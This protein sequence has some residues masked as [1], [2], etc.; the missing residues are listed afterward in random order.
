MIT[1]EMY[2]ERREASL[3]ALDVEISRLT[4]YADGADAD[5]AL[6]YD[7]VIHHLET[8]RDRAAKQLQKLGVVSCEESARAEAL[9]D[10][11]HQW[12]ELRNAVLVAISATYREEDES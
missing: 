10:M 5:V 3:R 11:E 12:R 8:T 7:E 4:D 9:R 2:I 1:S 6:N